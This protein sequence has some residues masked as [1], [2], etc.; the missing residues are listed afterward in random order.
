M[1]ADPRSNPSNEDINR[2]LYSGLLRGTDYRYIQHLG[3]GA[4]GEVVEAEDIHLGVRVALKLLM[5]RDLDPLPEERARR[6]DRMR[7]EAQ[8]CARL[9]HPS[10]LRV[11]RLGVTPAGQTYL[12]S[13]R[14]YGRTVREEIEARGELPVEEA[15]NIA[16]AILDG[17]AVAHAAGIVHRDIKHANVFLCDGPL[18]RP[19][20]VK[21]L[22]FG[23]AK[24]FAAARQ[25]NTPAPL[26]IPTDTGTSLGTPRFMAP[27]QA[28]GQRA[29]DARADI[30]STGALLYMMLTGR[31][32]FDHHRGV[33]EILSAHCTEPPRAPSERAKQVIVP[34]LDRAVLRALAK[35]PDARFATA[36]EFADVLRAIYLRPVQVSTIP[37]RATTPSQGRWDVTEPLTV[38]K[39]LPP[40]RSAPATVRGTMKMDVT[41]LEAAGQAYRASAAPAAVPVVPSVIGAATAEL[42]RPAATVELP[43]SVPTVELAK[44]AA[45]VRTPREVPPTTLPRQP[46][47][48]KAV[49]AIAAIVLVAALAIAL[50]L[51]S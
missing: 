24:V 17:L 18:D 1:V 20:R 10:I 26:M 32:P 27:E 49:G 29:I 42:G 39:D 25:P 30:Y 2:E 4:A 50:I 11:T 43:S 45:T 12:I 9:D 35:E 23:L 21:I 3:G 48:P 31:G 37:M 28:L 16:C 7:L 44:R 22:D 19:G 33:F 5:E 38:P 46:V 8:A 41:G 40:P 34:D 47:S 14:L 15:V 51:R 13:E 36:R 6:E